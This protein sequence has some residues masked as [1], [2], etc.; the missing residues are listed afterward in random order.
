M[1]R[2][3]A[4][5]WSQFRKSFFSEADQPAPAAR[6]GD[7]APDPRAAEP[8]SLSLDVIGQRSEIVKHR[9]QMMADRLDDLKSLQDDFGSIMTPLAAMADELS[10]ASGR[11]M[12]LEALLTQEQQSGTSARRELSELA[13]R[14]ASTENELALAQA[15]KSQIEAGLGERDD[16]IE[17]LRISLRDR[18][19]SFE[20]LERQLYSV[21]EQAK[22]LQGENK[23][24]RLEAQATDQALIRAEHELTELRERHNLADQDNRRLQLLSEEQGVKLSD[25]DARH[26]EAAAAADNERQ[27]LR[28]VEALLAA[29][30]AT[31][32]KNDA[33][34]EA[35]IATHRTERASLAMKF[36]AATNRLTSTEQ[37]VS[38]LRNQL[39]EK[40]EAGRV[41]ERT[42]KEVS[43]ERVTSDRRVEALQAD[44]A[45]QTERFVELQRLR[46]EL[47][48]R[49]DMLT[50]AMAA[51]DAALEQGASQIAALTDRMDQIT[52]RHETDRNELE[53]ANRR[54]IEEL[55]TERSE[56]AMAL[57]ALEIARESRASLQKQYESLKRS[58][59]DWRGDAS[60]EGSRHDASAESADAHTNVRPFTAPGK[61]N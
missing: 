37:L 48:N 46:S 31:R 32:E 52:R 34:Y 23:A 28:E 49:C 8:R 17:E 18:T 1:I 22:A 44:I 29:E 36:E 13:R 56:R 57:G 59:R 3:V 27:R 54:L 2:G 61:G 6:R 14:I 10:R 55:Q 43:I 15:R 53:I 20:N 47:T 25:L 9:I 35:E 45:R 19:L 30:K 12:E 7:T 24:L 40:D 51:K 5:A 41:V 33:Q 50:K 38:Q 60:G 42:L 26:S 11:N 39:R 4:M 21:S 58:A 16:A